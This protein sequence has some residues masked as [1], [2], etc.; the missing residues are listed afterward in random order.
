MNQGA[1][2]GVSPG[3]QCPQHQEAEGERQAV[4][5]GAYGGRRGRVR[6]TKKLSLLVLGLVLAQLAPEPVLAATALCKPRIA[7]LSTVKIP[8][9]YTLKCNL[10]LSCSL[11]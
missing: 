4:G 2:V 3:E 9:N 11:L 6:G 7:L 1:A 10:A 5:Q 8:Q